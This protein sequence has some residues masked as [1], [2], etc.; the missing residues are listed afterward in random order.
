MTDGQWNDFA[1][2]LLVGAVALL[3]LA[4][5]AWHQWREDRR[6]KERE[7]RAQDRQ[8]EV[9]LELKHVRDLALGVV[10]NRI[11]I[12]TQLTDHETRITRLEREPVARVR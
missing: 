5:V 7:D 9:L 3:N 10:K 2:L 6:A 12:E 11:W 8:T 4:A 1:L